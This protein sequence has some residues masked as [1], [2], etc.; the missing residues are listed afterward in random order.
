VSTLAKSSL[1]RIAGIMAVVLF[2]IV[3]ILQLML[4][5]GILPVSMS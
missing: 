3:I 1:S 4:A 5:A 2:G